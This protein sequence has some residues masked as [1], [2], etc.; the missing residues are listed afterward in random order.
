[1][2][3]KFALFLACCVVGGLA[4]SCNDTVEWG[5][6]EENCLEGT[7]VCD[8]N[9]VKTCKNGEYEVTEECGS[10][11]VC[12]VATKTCVD[13]PISGCIEN[14][15]QCSTNNLQVCKGGQ[16]Q[17]AE[18]CGA[19]KTCN[20][21]AG[22]C[23]DNGGTTCTEGDTR[24]DGDKIA[25]CGADGTYGESV[26]CANEGEVCITGDDGKAAC[27]T[28]SETCE[29][30]C[31]DDILTTC[32]ENGAAV[33]KPCGEGETCGVVDG[34]PACVVKAACVEGQQKCEGDQIVTCGA[35]GQ[36]GDPADCETD[37]EVCSSA[38]DGSGA[39]VAPMG[40]D[41]GD[42]TVD[43]GAKRCND[44]APQICQN[45]VWITQEA[46]AEPTVCDAGEC[47]TCINDDTKCETSDGEEAKVHTVSKCVDHEWIVET[48]DCAAEGMVCAGKTCGYVREC[49]D[50]D[51][52]SFCT[53][54]N[55][56]LVHC[57]FGTSNE[58]CPNGTACNADTA[59]CEKPKTCGNSALDVGEVCDGT[60]FGDQT[61]ATETGNDDAT[62]NLTC[63]NDCTEISVMDCYYC[64]DYYVNVDAGEECD[65]MFF[66]EGKRVCPEGKVFATGKTDKDITCSDACSV[67]IPDGVCVDKCTESVCTDGDIQVCNTETGVMAPSAKCTND[68]N[69]VNECASTTECKPFTCKDGF[70]NEAGVCVANC[71]ADICSDGKIQVC[72]EDGKLGPA[73]NCTDDPNAVNAC[74]SATACS[75]EVICLGGYHEKDGVCV[76]NCKANVCAA[77]KLQVCGEDGKLGDATDC[78][79]ATN[80]ATMAC[81]AA[82]NACVIA[83]CA[84]DYELNAEGT[85]CVAKV[86][87]PKS[88]K[89]KDGK[90]VADTDLGC[91][92]A[93]TLSTCDKG[94]WSKEP[95]LIKN[96]FDAHGTAVCDSMA[97]ACKVTACNAGYEPNATN[98]ACVAKVEPPKSCKDKDGKDVADTD[99][100]CSDATTLSTCDKGTWSKEPELIKNCFD[101]HGTAVCDSMALACK[102]TAC[103][104]GYEPNATNTACVESAY[105]AIDACSFV[106]VKGTK[107]YGRVMVM[108]TG[109]T[110]PS[111]YETRVVCGADPTQVNAW[112]APVAASKNAACT[113]GEEAECGVND[114]LGN[115][116]EFVA[117]LS[118]KAAGTHTCVFEA[119]VNEGSWYLCGAGAK[120]W[121]P[122]VVMEAS[123]DA[124]DK[125]QS[126]TVEGGALW[127][128][129]VEAPEKYTSSNNPLSTVDIQGQ[130][131]TQG[132]TNGM[133]NTYDWNKGEIDFN[134][135]Y[136]KFTFTPEQI[137]A[138]S[139]KLILGISFKY[140]S[141]NGNVKKGGVA[142]CNGDVCGDSCVFDVSTDM[143]TL[144]KEDCSLAFANTEG[145]S[146]RFV[147]TGT[148]SDSKFRI[149]PVTI[150]A[151]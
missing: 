137:A 124:T 59:R 115:N 21:A 24:C 22:K 151:K 87:P 72:G 47:V 132:A 108:G 101:A 25:T 86:E 51:P 102:V 93:T 7:V 114:G 2:N 71:T 99:L 62:G 16:W 30:G 97:L 56:Y 66:A 28:R 49:T 3:K 45:G 122:P 130:V 92:D 120:G 111:K 110:D 109:E 106:A 121:V 107:A 77:G 140:N 68:P 126:V 70:H 67:V 146:L 84:E 60:L 88:C 90:D 23:D 40:C 139:G 143:K 39:C 113:T 13:K 12:D 11:K 34:Q 145:L 76:E 149:G 81:N 6:Q 91:S 100:G 41:A 138:L 75:T 73:A 148:G 42:S 50:D 48:E 29:P 104:E 17:L 64:G 1:M 57:I 144:N 37:G 35:D 19:D 58:M 119:R 63:I 14:T 55:K 27:G 142:V 10:T 103:N 5:F 31:V 46:C 83:T 33:Q 96:C 15:Y 69:A 54:D 26:A 129:I 127:T 150:D 4:A 8:S 52:T 20:A 112:T 147:A 125:T 94:T 98:T 53:D 78:A 116:V 79:L 105:K 123:T 128:N 9:A 18:A 95:E 118:G 135:P 80:A 134:S 141:K 133:Y 136:V 65:K 117:D 74:A 43:H 32:D 89:D 38:V 44:S 131:L 82:G 61:C 36:W 85:A